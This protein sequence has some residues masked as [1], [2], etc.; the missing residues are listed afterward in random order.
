MPV[1]VESAD[2]DVPSAQPQEPGLIGRIVR[3]MLRR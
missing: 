2:A 3:W 1:V